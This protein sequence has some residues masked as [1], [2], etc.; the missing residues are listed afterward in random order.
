[1][2]PKP[3]ILVIGSGWLRRH[4]AGFVHPT[5]AN[6]GYAALREMGKLAIELLVAR[7]NG[8][9]RQPKYYKDE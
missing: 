3:D 9:N 6:H 4:Y 7:V 2:A 8:E 1:M 5:T